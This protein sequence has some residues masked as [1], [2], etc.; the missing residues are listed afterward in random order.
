MALV[1]RLIKE[2]ELSW[3]ELDNNFV[4]LDN[5][6]DD[7][8]QGTASAGIVRVTPQTFLQSE[9]DQALANIGGASVQ[10]IE[11]IENRVEF[12]ETY[13]PVLYTPQVL[14]PEEKQQALANLGI[15]ETLSP[16][17]SVKSVVVEY[18]EQQINI[19]D[20]KTILRYN[21]VYPNCNISNALS[22]GDELVIINRAV[23]EVPFVV[24]MNV[25]LQ[26]GTV[27]SVFSIQPNKNHTFWFDKNS[28]NWIDVSN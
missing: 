5:R 19:T 20:N 8:E 2:S 24:N 10:V 1:L 7:L 4:Y 22:D 18:E 11:E 26:N 17:R 6:I 3:E 27:S 28:G 14:T 21:N 25:V 16:E 15:N 9:M 23:T 13:Q 12:L